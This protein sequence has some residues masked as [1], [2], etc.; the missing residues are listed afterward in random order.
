MKKK[1]IIIL[2][3]LALGGS[4][5]AQISLEYFEKGLVYY[6]LG[7]KPEAQKRFESFFEALREPILRRGYELLLKGEMWDS[8]RV[9]KNYLKSNKY[10]VMALVGVALSNEDVE[11]RI[12]FLHRAI[13]FHPNKPQSC[14][15]LAM[16]YLKKENYKLARDW[17]RKA[18]QFATINEYKLIYA[19]IYLV[20]EE[21]QKV[22]DIL[23][24]ER[25]RMRENFYFNFFIS[26][27]FF[28]INQLKDKKIYID[29]A[30]SLKP[31]DLETRILLAKYYLKAEDYRKAHMILRELKSRAD[32]F[33]YYLLYAELLLKLKD[34]RCLQYLDEAFMKNRWHPELNKLYAAYYDWKKDPENR[35]KM[36]IRAIISGVEP[37]G[38]IELYPD[39]ADDRMVRE[40]PSL[41]FFHVKTIEWLGPETILV[42]GSRRFD[43]REAL[44]IID[45]NRLQVV[46][47]F[48]YPGVFD[49][50]FIFGGGDR[51]IFSVNTYTEDSVALYTVVNRRIVR[52]I[53]R[54]IP[55]PSIHVEYDPVL[56]H[57]YITD[58]RV[59]KSFLESPFVIKLRLGQKQ[60]V[61]PNYPF[62]IYRYSFSRPG[63][64][65]IKKFSDIRN[66]KIETIAQYYLIS[67]QR[68]FNPEL[69]EL[70]KNAEQYDLGSDEEVKVFIARD[71]SG[72]IV[73]Y[74]DLQESFRGILYLKKNNSY[75]RITSSEILGTDEYIGLKV[76]GLFP[77]NHSLLL[78]TVD[79]KK[80]L[81][82]YNYR[83]R[84]IN[85]LSNKCIDFYYHRGADE[86]YLLKEMNK[87]LQWTQA[88]LQIFAFNPFLKRVIKGNRTLEKILAVQ[89]GC[90][91]FLTY[92]G[93]LL[94]YDKYRPEEG[95]VY[96]Q[97]AFNT[98]VHKRRMDNFETIA[99]INKRLVYFQ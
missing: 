43:D 31:N 65:R 62:Y 11:E 71:L 95:F 91:Y 69:N 26:N 88:E 37:Q 17:I 99:F 63:I 1:I 32:T 79:E 87:M 96:L 94:R 38:M 97:P 21:Y 93:E 47:T 77:Q 92:N 82:R 84:L 34:N 59:K 22:I 13:R 18:I 35:R 42:V 70:I 98:I 64:V 51:V 48:R 5:L 52:Q 2:V 33:N 20:M 90:L 61:F 36:V 60:P 9:F 24:P 66:L 76:V 10:S 89:G 54:S 85:K 75:T 39:L 16:E 72:F 44:S 15:C 41:P 14:A 56:D 28:S 73:Y 58:A 67:E 74:S 86:I 78:L 25:E 12:E 8:N 27:A 45:L 7:D 3:M 83:T 80:T 23:L 6:L 57:A 40:Y 81:I 49:R 29:R 30:I 55:I 50:V 19:K 68:N 46:T 4:V 53:T